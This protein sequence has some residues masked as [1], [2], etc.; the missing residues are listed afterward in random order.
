M[1]RG[2]VLRATPEGPTI[3]VGGRGLYAPLAP[4]TSARRRAEA[5]DLPERCI[6]L[7]P[8]VG[9][10]YGL[11]T[12]AGRCPTSSHI[13]CV[14]VD[15]SIMALAVAAG[16]I[17][18]APRL[19]VFRTDDPQ[20]VAA[21]ARRLGL[22]GYRR[23]RLVNLC[24]GYPLHRARYD[25]IFRT[26]ESLLAEYWQN[27]MTQIHLGALWV[28]NCLE[29]VCLVPGSV[30][31]EDYRSPGAVYVAGAGPTLDGCIEALRGRPPE[32]RLLAVDTA[33]PIL[34]AHGVRPDL[35]F[36]L[37]AQHANL[38][39]FLPRPDTALPVIADL[40][41]H[42]ASLRLF[43]GPRSLVLTGF[44]DLGLFRRMADRGLRP[45]PLRPLGSVGVAA[46]ALALELTDGPVIT[47]GLDFAYRGDRTH[48][49]GAPFHRMA[50]SRSTR[51]D[52]VLNQHYRVIHRRPLRAPAGEWL[53]DAVLD[54]Y[55]VTLRDLAAGAAGR[56]RRLTEDGLV[57]D[58]TP[59]ETG[60]L[61]GAPPAS[62]PEA[63]PPSPG[64]AT[65]SAVADLYREE[66]ELIESTLQT[67]G[68]PHADPAGLAAV[69]YAWAHFPES[70][71]D[72][73]LPLPLPSGYAARVRQALTVYRGRI[74]R[75]AARLNG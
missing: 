2:A 43:R 41:A 15:Q 4:R 57:E 18:R 70:A 33:L 22:E 11:E 17:P 74:R 29:N 32:A 37:E 73:P 46:C 45:R 71:A 34:E 44:R 24:G 42:P 16:Q 1:S 9:L 19:S 14:E 61:L 30:P 47:V 58:W 8:S 50:L 3:E 64:L 39:D 75:L 38:Y 5:A 20:V 23:C 66:L 65:R 10:G 68:S 7:V 52:P 67:L 13:L 53:S 55:A 56:I 72:E 60:E 63:A 12:L 54:S 6:V 25:H 35:V 31:L 27:R 62:T 28:K 48:A 36:I 59:A 26:L 69:D 51:V 21:L 40:T 49:R